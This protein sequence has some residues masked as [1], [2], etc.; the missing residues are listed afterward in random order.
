M[1][2]KIDCSLIRGL[3]EGS[4]NKLEIDFERL[5]IK[6]DGGDVLTW[7]WGEDN[8]RFKGHWRKALSKSINKSI[9][10]AARSLK[11]AAARSVLNSESMNN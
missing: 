4:C 1:F 11:D 2:R 8:K 10:R 5:S 7:A 6:L 9:R 3:E